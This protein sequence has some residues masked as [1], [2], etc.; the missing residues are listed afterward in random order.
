MDDDP[1]KNEEKEEHEEKEEEKGELE[2]EEKPKV[3]QSVLRHRE[4]SKVYHKVKLKL[5]KDGRDEA[6][7][8]RRNQPSGLYNNTLVLATMDYY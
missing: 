7:A 2:E 8:K 3:S 4:Y 5:E 1:E 6:T